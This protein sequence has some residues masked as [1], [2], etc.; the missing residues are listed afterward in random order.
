[1]LT[2]FQAGKIKLLLK[3]PLPGPIL[4]KCTQI[5]NLFHLIILSSYQDCRGVIN[6]VFIG[7]HNE[8]V[9]VFVLL[10]LSATL[11]NADHSILLERAEAFIGIKRNVMH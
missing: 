7:S 4:A 9:F 8:L 5:P 1:M 10:D 11:K 2:S 3:K 6:Y